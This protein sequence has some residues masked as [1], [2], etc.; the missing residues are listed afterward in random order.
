MLLR[1]AVIFR[2]LIITRCQRFC[3]FF[4]CRCRFFRAASAA[5]FA[6][7]PLYFA[8]SRCDA[9]D[10]A[11]TLLLFASAMPVTLRR[12]AAALCATLSPDAITL[13]YVFDHVIFVSLYAT[14]YYAITLRHAIAFA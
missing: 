11:A 13:D 12:F 1:H 2:C 4:F 5:I 8:I 3:R 14:P 9:L 7:M 10:I 6:A